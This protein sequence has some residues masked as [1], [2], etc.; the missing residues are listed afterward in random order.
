MFGKCCRLAACSSWF[1]GQVFEP[2]VLGLSISGLHLVR[3]RLRVRCLDLNLSG[4]GLI[5]IP[6]SGLAVGSLGWPLSGL[7]L[8]Y[9]FTILYIG[10]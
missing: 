5:G 10:P 8:K 4:L 9:K 2:A 3:R 7:P 6:E 1:C